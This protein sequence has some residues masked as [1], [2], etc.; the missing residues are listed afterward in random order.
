MHPQHV[1]W[2]TMGEW[3]YYS[4][5]IFPTVVSM[6]LCL[7]ILQSSITNGYTWGL[8]KIYWANYSVWHQHICLRMLQCTNPSF[9]WIWFDQSALNVHSKYFRSGAS[10]SELIPSSHQVRW[11]ALYKQQVTG[12]TGYSSFP[13]LAALHTIQ[14]LSWRSF[15]RA[16]WC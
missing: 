7:F 15:C 9:H 14:S 2:C 1:K 3:T 5:L 12:T 11:F 8:I 4:L 16:W 6:V 13:W 10:S